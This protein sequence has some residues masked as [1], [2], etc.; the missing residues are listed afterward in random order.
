MNSKHQTLNSNSGSTVSPISRKT[1]HKPKQKS[2]RCWKVV[3][4]YRKIPTFPA[5][6]RKR[7][8]TGIP[9]SPCCK[10]WSDVIT[11]KAELDSLGNMQH[12]KPWQITPM[13]DAL[14]Q[15]LR[16]I[17]A[18]YPQIELAIL[19]GS[20]ANGRATPQSDIDLAVQADKPLDATLKMALI[21]DLAEA[22]GKNGGTHGS[23]S[24]RPK[25]RIP[26]PI[27]TYHPH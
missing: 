6:S 24:N 15:Q 12:E 17:L 1:T 14:D 19:F 22:F 5:T 16:D 3:T 21:G 8:K 10:H 9:T 25:T 27:T 7:R 11:G 4:R 18:N 20:M 23:T 26:A 13:A 2:W